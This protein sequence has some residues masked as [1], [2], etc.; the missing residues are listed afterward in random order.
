MQLSARIVAGLTGIGLVLSCSTPLS[1]HIANVEAANEGAGVYVAGSYFVPVDVPLSGQ[2]VGQVIELADGRIVGFEVDESREEPVALVVRESITATENLAFY[3]GDDL[4]SRTSFYVPPVVIGDRW[5]IVETAGH[6]LWWDF[7]H[8][9]DT[10][11]RFDFPDPHAR[12]NYLDFAPLSDRLF[13]FTFDESGGLEYVIDLEA[14]KV[15]AR[16]DSDFDYL[17]TLTDVD[18]VWNYRG[19]G[20][21]TA[22]GSED[23]FL[24][25][26]DFSIVVPIPHGTGGRDWFPPSDQGVLRWSEETDGGQVIMVSYPTD[27]HEAI[28]YDPSEPFVQLLKEQAY[29]SAIISSRRRAYVLDEELVIWDAEAGRVGS[30]PIPTDGDIA[31]PIEDRDT[32]YRIEVIAVLDDGRLLTIFNTGRVITWDLSGNDPVPT[33]Q[34]TTTRTDTGTRLQDQRR[35]PY[36]ITEDG[37]LV[38]QWFETEGVSRFTNELQIIKLAD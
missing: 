10:V 27:G 29:E 38:I 9:P 2:L 17:R 23:A 31:V 8:Q 12:S 28:P 15:R 35:Y 13:Y 37:H 32:S 19:T 16:D 20:W 14:N 5:M 26:A 7:E 25:N 3:N 22:S 24:Y 34:F 1:E 11:H 33:I 18:Q 36:Q 30:A 21:Y 6:L 4:M